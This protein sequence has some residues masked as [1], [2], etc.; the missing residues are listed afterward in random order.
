V[1]LEYGVELGLPG[2]ALFVALIVFSIRSVRFAQQRAGGVPALAE[3]R[4]LAEGIQISLFAFVVAGM[5]HPGGYQFGFYYFA[6][7]AAATRAIAESHPA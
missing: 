4:Y 6:G 2:L 7:L 5:F 1:Y 3:L